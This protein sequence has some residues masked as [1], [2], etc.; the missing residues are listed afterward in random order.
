VSTM[1]QAF[2]LNRAQKTAAVYAAIS[3]DWTWEVQTVAQ[4]TER[5][6]EVEAL[7]DGVEELRLTMVQ[8]RSSMC[9]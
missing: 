2:I 9:H 6:A 1:S 7:L 8:K 5:K 4:F 3:P